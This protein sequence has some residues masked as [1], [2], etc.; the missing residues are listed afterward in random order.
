MHLT[1]YIKQLDP[2]SITPGSVMEDDNMRKLKKYAQ[3]DITEID[4]LYETT[5]DRWSR[6]AK[7][8]LAKSDIASAPDIQSF[9]ED[10]TVI[11]EGQEVQVKVPQGPKGTIGIMLEGHLKMVHQSR[12]TKLDEGVMGGVMTMSPINRMMQLAGLEHTGAVAVDESDSTLEEDAGAGNM[13]NQL[14]Q[15]NTTAPAYKNNPQAAKIATVG[16]VLAGLQSVLAELSNM[17]LPTNIANQLKIVPGIG[18][19]L[20]KAANDLT[21]GRQTAGSMTK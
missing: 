5:I 3:V 14:L 12:I 18:A 15:K 9:D 11:Y 17:D 21:T 1:D 13:F 19:S 8:P 7:H 16:Q 6:N 10:E 20:I 2:T 4:G